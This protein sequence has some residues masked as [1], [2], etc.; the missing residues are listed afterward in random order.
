MNKPEKV[1]ILRLR[2]DDYLHVDSLRFE[3]N[4]AVGGLKDCRE[5]LQQN[6]DKYIQ[7]PWVKKNRREAIAKFASLLE[8]LE[9]YLTRL[10]MHLEYRTTGTGACVQELWQIQE[11]LNSEQNKDILKKEIV[12]FVKEARQNKGGDRKDVMEITSR[13]ENITHKLNRAF[14]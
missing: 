13:I 5:G 2:I 6:V 8:E 14:R 9:N 7:W 11:Y 1:E 3:L 10:D 12:Q 4:D